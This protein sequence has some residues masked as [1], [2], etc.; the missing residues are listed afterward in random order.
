MLMF[1]KLFSNIPLF[2]ET[3]LIHRL[4]FFG[5]HK[6]VAIFY[7]ITIIFHGYEFPEIPHDESLHWGRGGWGLKYGNCEKSFCDE[8]LTFLVTVLWFSLNFCNLGVLGFRQGR[9]TCG[10]GRIGTPS[11]VTERRN[12]S[13]CLNP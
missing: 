12:D 11:S 5:F 6:F 1:F 9:C 3:R 10:S 7:K 8:K 4:I 2:C 13:E